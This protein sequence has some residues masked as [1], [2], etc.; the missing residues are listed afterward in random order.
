MQPPP[1]VTV[2]VNEQDA[3]LVQ[4]LVAVNATVVVPTLNAK[5]LP[6]PEPLPVVAPAKEYVTIGDI[7][8][9]AVAV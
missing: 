2:T 6:V 5:P 7:L 4:L 3:V 1:A 8:P 9:P